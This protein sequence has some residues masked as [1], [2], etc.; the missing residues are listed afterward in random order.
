MMAFENGWDAVLQPEF[1]KPYYQAL[2][3]TLKREYARTTVYPDM[4]DLFNAFKYTDFDA[5]R[6]VIVGQDPYHGPGQAHGL[7]F[8]VKK[9]VPVPPSLQNIY[10]EQQN[11]VGTT[12]PGHGC[13]TDWA[14]QGVLL[15]NAV[16]S[17]RAS[18]PNSHKDIGWAQLT[19]AVF[20]HLNA[21]AQ[22]MVFLLWGAHAKQKAAHITNPDHL[23]LTAP[24]PS[25]LSAHRGFFGC[26][27]FS[28]TNAFLQ[29]HG[30]APINWQL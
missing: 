19:D 7:S 5:V 11:D 15:L 6:C 29:Q 23:V 2:R 20:A 17:V 4:Y 28:R 22:P 9:G 26:K 30:M 10:Q 14:A 8:S 13:L 3:Q 27:H 1:A 16:L 12:P 18:E 24:H 25:P 21:R